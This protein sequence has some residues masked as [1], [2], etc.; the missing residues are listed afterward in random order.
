MLRI[1]ICETAVK[2]TNYELLN[3]FIKFVL[4]EFKTQLTNFIFTL[5]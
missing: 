4:T 1:L 2:V 3:L 5:P